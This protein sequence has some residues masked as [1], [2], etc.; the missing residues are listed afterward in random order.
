MKIG[1]ALKEATSLLKEITD[2][3]KKEAMLL[4]SSVLDKDISYLILNENSEFVKED[5]FFLLVK[6]RAEGEPLE[7][8]FKKVS[9]Y[10]NE[11]FIGKGALIPRPETELLIDEVIKNQDYI[12]KKSI[13][14]AEIGIGS[15][16]I[17]IMLALK[18]KDVKIVATDISKDALRIAKK[19]ID[20]FNL[21][22]KIELHYGSYL[23]G[24]DKELD[25]I[26]S[27][28]PYVADD[29]KIE[30]PLKYE[31]KEAIFGGKKGDEV[32]AE[33]IPLFK[34][35]KAKLLCCEIGY[36]QKESISKILKDYNFDNFYFYKDLCGL[37]RGF[38]V[39]N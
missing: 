11:F 28:P 34:K 18:L 23:D 12:G 15:G 1:S 29:F 10:S 9:F 6:R 27:N 3:P 13:N 5:E 32:L 21:Q 8:I 31:P 36:D 19:N 14:I 4:A 2:I 30:K 26:V 38:I 39:K 33:I 37:D 25:I 16:V 24:I 17:S 35:S 7:Y 22:D 20:K